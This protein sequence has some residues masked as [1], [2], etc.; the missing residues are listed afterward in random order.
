MLL[1]PY[2]KTEGDVVIHGYRLLIIYW[3]TYQG[4]LG[5]EFVLI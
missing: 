4:I 2:I 1:D 3:T 5:R